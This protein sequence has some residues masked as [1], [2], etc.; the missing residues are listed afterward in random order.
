MRLFT[1]GDSGEPVRD[2]QGRLS[3][4]GFTSQDPVGE[5]G[6][7]TSQAVVAFQKA[8]GLDTDALVGRETWRALYEAGYTLGDRVLF[9]RRPLLRGDDVADLQQ[10]LNEL[11]F[12][13]GKVDGM[14][15]PLA[16]V[17]LVDFQSNRGMVEDGIA[18]PAVVGELKGITRTATVAGRERVRELEWLRNLPSTVVGARIYLDPAGYNNVAQDA[19]WSLAVDLARDFQKLGGSPLLSRS[20]DTYPSPHTRAARANRLGAQ[21]TLSFQLAGEQEPGVFYFASQHSRSEA[22]ALLASSVGNRI[23]LEQSGR[24]ST[25]LK[26][27]RAPALMIVT[28]PRPG[29]VQGIVSGVCDFFATAAHATDAT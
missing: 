24:A 5:F 11:G 8:Q 10:R 17:A 6:P 15:G 3:A 28:E 22:G 16:H 9:H 19:A 1:E 21:L 13:A 2:I 14:F 12:D 7:G 23:Q 18:G 29:I 27:T 4:L 25:I 26:E 20:V